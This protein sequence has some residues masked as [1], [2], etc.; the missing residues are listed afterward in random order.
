MADSIN[1][2][3]PD[4]S[5]TVRAQRISGPFAR[6]GSETA[7]VPSQVEILSF[8]SVNGQA[9]SL[10]PPPRSSQT[11]QDEWQVL[12]QAADISVIRKDWPDDR[13]R[14]TLRNFVEALTDEPDLPPSMRRAL[15]NHCTNHITETQAKLPYFFYGASMFPSV[16]WALYRDALA[17][18]KPAGGPAVQPLTEFTGRFAP[19]ILPAHRLR[20]VRNKSTPACIESGKLEVEGQDDVDDSAAMGMVAFVSEEILRDKIHAFQATGYKIKRVKVWVDDGGHVQEL[21]ALTYVWNKSTAELDE[22]QWD[23]SRMLQD[24]WFLNIIKH[25]SVQQAETLI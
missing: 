21:E 10:I 4:Q 16:L 7:N 14:A 1:I 20:P 6:G 8:M 19:A 3:V 15:Q 11:L 9:C 13:I 17:L 25:P 12:A 18:S 2:T 22:G 24:P 5:L 23:I